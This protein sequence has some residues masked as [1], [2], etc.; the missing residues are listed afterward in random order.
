MIN[1]ISINASAH[2]EWH[3]FNLKLSQDIIFC[4]RMCFLAIQGRFL[5]HP[6]PFHSKW[7]QMLFILLF[8]SLYQLSRPSSAAHP[9]LYILGWYV[10]ALCTHG[11]AGT[12][13]APPH[14]LGALLLQ[15]HPPCF[16]PDQDRV[17]TSES[18]LCASCTLWIFKS[19]L[20]GSDTQL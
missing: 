12:S 17:L 10:C 14:H 5:I 13:H 6:S 9:D 7:P 4:R 3:V 16:S 1:Y 8:R 2:S 19:L 18:L 20:S 11:L 15:G